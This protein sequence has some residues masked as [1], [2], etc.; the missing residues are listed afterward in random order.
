MASSLP[1]LII[2]VAVRVRFLLANSLP[3]VVNWFALMVIFSFW[4]FNLA[5]APICR[6]PCVVILIFFL[7]F[8]R[9]L[10]MLA[11]WLDR[12]NLPLFTF[13]LAIWSLSVP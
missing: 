13:S 10:S 8:R 9:A 12:V 6:S 7:A 11:D 5:P 3:W 1:W 2:F 4:L